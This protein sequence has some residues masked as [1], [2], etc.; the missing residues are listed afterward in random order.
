MKWNTDS[1]NFHSVCISYFQDS[2]SASIFCVP[3]QCIADNHMEELRPI[4]IS[5]LLRNHILVICLCQIC[6]CMQLLLSCQL[7]LLYECLLDLLPKLSNQTSSFI[8][9][10]ENRPPVEIHYCIPTI[11]WY[12]SCDTLIGVGNNNVIIYMVYIFL[13]PS[14]VRFG[15]FSKVCSGIK[16]AIVFT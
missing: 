9:D 1:F 6:L 5:L 2:T 7:T 4:A 13:P 12:I 16:V 8:S 11:R 15:C 14:N 3:G 10:V